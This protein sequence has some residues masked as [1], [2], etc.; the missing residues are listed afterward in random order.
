MNACVH[1]SEARSPSISGPWLG[2]A[3]A[4]AALG[5]VGWAGAVL[6]REPVTQWFAISASTWMV[7]LVVTALWQLRGSVLAI[8]AFA[9][10]TA[11]IARLFSILRVHPPASIVGMTADQ[12]DLQVATGPGIE[13]FE[14]LGWVMGALVFARFLSVARVA[15]VASGTQTWPHATTAMTFIRIYLGLMF[16]PHFCSHV[17]GGPFQFEVYTVYFQSLGIHMPAAQVLLAGTVEI[18]TAVGLVLGF[19]TRP[20]A[21][22]G[23]VYLLISMFLGGHFHIGYVWALP[24]GGYE[25]GVFWA[26]MIAVFAVIGGGPLS[27]DREVLQWSELRLP[28]SVRGLTQEL[29]S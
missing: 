17:L 28:R 4:I 16:V 5:M 11:V 25:F 1:S 29:L 2:T 10:S 20:V 15:L 19:L 3:I 9:L 7:L 13:G 8:V 23:S 12:L 24:E 18:I 21:V 26:A 27:A 22:L 14:L 6:L